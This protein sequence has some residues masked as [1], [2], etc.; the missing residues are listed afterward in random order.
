VSALRVVARGLAELADTFRTVRLAALL[1]AGLC[2][3]FLVESAAQAVLPASTE[4]GV[5]VA[6]NVER[7]TDTDTYT[8]A[9]VLDSGQ[10]IDLADRNALGVHATVSGGMPVLVTRSHADGQVLSVRT[11]E[12]SVDTYSYSG[13][14]VLRV[15]A[16]VGLVGGL[17]LGLRGGRRDRWWAGRAGGVRRAHL[18]LAVDRARAHPHLRPDG[19]DGDLRRPSL[20]PAG[21]GAR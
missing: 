21:G 1:L 16:A 13:A 7:G 2:A 6:N 19:R 14:W 10:A 8:I 12:E 20:A 17:A 5:V 18:G 4:R 15:G 11:P 9:A 3:A